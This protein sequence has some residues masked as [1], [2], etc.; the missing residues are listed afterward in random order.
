MEKQEAH[1]YISKELERQCDTMSMLQFECIAK[2]QV[3]RLNKQLS[4]FE[5][6]GCVYCFL[7]H[8]SGGGNDNCK[9]TCGNWCTVCGE[10]WSHCNCKEA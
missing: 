3:I 2:A 7:E 5:L 9:C 4:S 8:S 1:A 10:H 6:T